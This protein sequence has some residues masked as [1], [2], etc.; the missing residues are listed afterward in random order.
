MLNPSRLVCWTSRSRLSKTGDDPS[1]TVTVCAFVSTRNTTDVPQAKY[2][3]T[4]SS[5]SARRSPGERT[6]TTALGATRGI[7]ASS[8]RSNGTRSYDKYAT[9]GTSGRRTSPGGAIRNSHSVPTMP[10]PRSWVQASS[11]ATK[12]DCASACLRR[13]LIF[14]RARPLTHSR[15]GFAIGRTICRIGHLARRVYHTSEGQGK[16]ET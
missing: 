3:R 5:I 9:S 12:R 4:F 15:A 7:S 13:G 2:T 6:S 14:W 8:S 1:L 11:A 10:Q 16:N